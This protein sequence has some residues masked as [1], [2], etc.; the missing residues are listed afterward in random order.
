MYG[1]FKV[2]ERVWKRGLNGAY[3]TM[4]NVEKVNSEFLSL[5]Y[6]MIKLN[7]G[8]KNQDR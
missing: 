7:V 4:S 1:T 6:P 5:S 3:K 2:R 8:R